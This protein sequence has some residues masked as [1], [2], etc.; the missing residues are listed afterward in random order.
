ML[1][2]Y[3]FIMRSSDSAVIARIGDSGREA[4]ASAIYAA[5]VG[6]VAPYVDETLGAVSSP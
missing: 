2:G 4:F 6:E 3:G 5:Y 1:V